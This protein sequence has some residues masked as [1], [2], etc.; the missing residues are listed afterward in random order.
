M[1]KV[2]TCMA[3]LCGLVANADYI[4]WMVDTDQSSNAAN[5]IFNTI[6]L[7][8][9]DS[10][11]AT[12]TPVSYEG[13]ASFNA[14]AGY[15]TTSISSGLSESTTSF[16]VELYNGSSWVAESNPISYSDLL[17]AGSIFKGGL[18]PAS[19]SPAAFGAYHVP[20]PTSG[21]LFLLGGVL[22]GLKRRRMA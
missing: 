7:R 2:L 5:Y 16:Y 4:Y 22:L 12:Y 9:A 3:L 14:D 13:L 6:R 8:D 1:K 20:E 17:A 18:T 10:V 19:I 15:F 21:L 11:Y